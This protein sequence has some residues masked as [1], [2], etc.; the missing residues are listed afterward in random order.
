MGVSQSTVDALD[1]YAR[2]DGHAGPP[3]QDPDGDASDHPLDVPRPSPPLSTRLKNWGR[4]GHSPMRPPADNA[5]KG[6][7]IG[8][9][10][11][12]WHT[13]AAAVRI[14]PNA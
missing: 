5:R 3:L 13:C 12:G 9:I 7:Y 10:L 4:A 8:A 14:D 6:T 2:E 1:G 11:E